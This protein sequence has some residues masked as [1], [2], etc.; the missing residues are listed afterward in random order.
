[1][2]RDVSK[3]FHGLHF[4]IFI[5][6]KMSLKTNMKIGISFDLKEEKNIRIFGST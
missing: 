3:H 2:L 6:F 4:K 5:D 1:M